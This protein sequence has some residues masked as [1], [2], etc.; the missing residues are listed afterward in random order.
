VDSGPEVDALHQ[1]L[2]R[3][4]RTLPE[5]RLSAAAIEQLALERAQAGAVLGDVQTLLLL[6]A[7]RGDDQLRTLAFWLSDPSVEPAEPY[8]ARWAALVR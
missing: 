1:E 5:D 2:V 4:A 8:R 6:G 7:L 3:V